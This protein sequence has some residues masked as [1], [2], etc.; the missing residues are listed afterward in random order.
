MKIKTQN[1]TGEA[2]DW[3]VAKALDIK[4][5]KRL[6]DENLPYCFDLFHDI[7]TLSEAKGILAGEPHCSGLGS[8]ELR[9][10]ATDM[11]YIIDRPVYPAYSTAW[12]Q[13]GPIIERERIH[14]RPDVSTQNF[15]AFVIRSPEGQQCRYVGATPLVAAMRCF[16]A[17]E[18]GEEVELPKELT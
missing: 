17:I 18:L 5:L 13:G 14:I 16:V 2:L 1:L 9:K 7:K 3:A 4:P 6:E 11:G 12:S 8:E 15:R 10:F